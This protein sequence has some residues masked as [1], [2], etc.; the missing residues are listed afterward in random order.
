MSR[1]KVR[2]RPRVLATPRVAVQG[3]GMSDP[4]A[5]VA[6]A[7]DD[8]RAMSFAKRAK[9]LERAAQILEAR[10]ERFARRMAREMGKPVTQGKAEVVK[11]ATACRHYAAHGEAML[12][13]VVEDGATILHQ[14]LGPVLA[15]MPW[16]FPFW[17]AFRFAAPALMAGNTILLKHASNV[18]GCARAIAEVIAEAFGRDDLLRA[19]FIAG[20]EVEPLIADARI[21]A[22]T[23]TGSTEAGRKVAAAAGRYLKKSVLELGGSDPYLVLDDADLP[24]AARICAAA[25]MV[26]AGQSCIAAT[27]FLVAEDVHDEFVGLLAKELAEFVPGDPRDEA[28]NLGPM[29]RTDLRDELHGQVMDSI[30]AGA[31]LLLGGE[32]PQLR[33][34]PYYPATLLAGVKPGM[35]VFDEETFGPVAA[36]TR[37]SGDAEMIALANRT[38]FGLGAAVFSAEVDR[39]R[40]VAEQLDTGTVAIN[41]QVVSDPRFPF[42]GVKDS[43]WGRELGKHGIREFVNVKTLRS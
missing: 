16:N 10:Q 37:V 5:A 26:N 4:L 32:V 9:G 22:V 21:R 33:D 25:R 23:F 40:R 34:L 29:A 43:G 36:V 27:R 31:R 13:P 18:P 41:A 3:G 11:C 38:P 35:R 2:V 8:L 19:V 30:A 42:G 20:K 28:C 24:S 15:I 12:A 1:A 14:P 7:F 39:A 17:Q 6:A